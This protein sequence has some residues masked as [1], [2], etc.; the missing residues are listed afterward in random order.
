M[1]IAAQVAVTFLAAGL[2]WVGG[3][4]TRFAW[5][6]IIGG[7]IGFSTAALYARYAFGVRGEKPR[8]F[9]KAHFRAEALKLAFTVVLLAAA[10]RIYKDVSILPL[11]L[12]YIATLSVYW[13]ALLWA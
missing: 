12:S 6:A 4:E 7:S 11:L 3:G 8:E 9:V 13:F 1:I 10:L 2:A 5:S